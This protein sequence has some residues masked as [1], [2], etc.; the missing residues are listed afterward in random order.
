MS[1]GND[2]HSWLNGTESG[3]VGRFM[4]LNYADELVNLIHS[5]FK[6]VQKIALDFIGHH[7]HGIMHQHHWSGSIWI[8]L[9][10]IRTFRQAPQIFPNSHYRTE[11]E[12]IVGVDNLKSVFTIYF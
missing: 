12:Y 4:E 7:N 9:S 1:T 11:L 6:L 10:F 2:G 8:L 3:W 5:Q